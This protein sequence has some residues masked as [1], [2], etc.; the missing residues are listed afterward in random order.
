MHKRRLVMDA[1]RA[2]VPFEDTAAQGHHGM[3]TRLFVQ[4][5]DIRLPIVQHLLRELAHPVVLAYKARTYSWQ[6]AIGIG[7]VGTP[8]VEK[9]HDQVSEGAGSGSTCSD[10]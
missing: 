4:L 3:A 7:W 1:A 2:P 10:N 9:G 6:V 5:D 8:F